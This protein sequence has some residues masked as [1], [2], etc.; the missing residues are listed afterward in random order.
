MAKNL[1]QDATVPEKIMWDILRNRRFKNLKFRRQHVINGYILDFYC[2]EICLAIEIDGNVHNDPD[3]AVYDRE[4]QT[5]L[6]KWGITF[7]RIKNNVVINRRPQAI[8]QLEDVTAGLMRPAGSLSRAAA[9]EGQGE[10][11]AYA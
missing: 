4:R 1:R 2:H 9:G 6:G 7:L 3:Q 11:R 8:R 10:G 5:S